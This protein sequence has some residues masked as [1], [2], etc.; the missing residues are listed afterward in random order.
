MSSTA[1][2]VPPY[3]FENKGTFPAPFTFSVPA[4]LEVRPDTATARFD[5]T[6]AS[7]NFLA[8]LTFYGT[9]GERL[10]RWFNPTVLTPGQVAE[11]TYT[12]PFGSAATSAAASALD[13]TN[14]VLSVNPTSE[15][16]IGSG[17]TLTNPSA[18]VAEFVAAGL[19]IPAYTNIFPD[20]TLVDS[21]STATFGAHNYAQAWIPTM[22]NH[23]PVTCYLS[24]TLGV[25]G[26]APYSIQGLPSI[27]YGIVDRGQSAFY[28]GAAY[29][30]GSG[31]WIPATIDGDGG[32]TFQSA[33]TFATG[34][35]LFSGFG[36]YPWLPN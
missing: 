11:V 25:V 12:P 16:F 8:C 19:T 31:T 9:D 10:G 23:Y 5:G 26:A 20:L 13:T 36:V 29:E 24:L 32:I 2:S 1:N 17:L 18:G 21:S 15:L 14:G 34:D 7:G 6:G 22:T 4:S 27:Q 28:V 33:P 30:A 3:V 35:T